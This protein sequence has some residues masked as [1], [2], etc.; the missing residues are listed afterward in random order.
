MANINLDKNKFSLN[1]VLNLCVVDTNDDGIPDALA[2]CNPDGSVIGQNTT[3]VQIKKIDKNKFNSAEIL[4]QVS[5]DIDGDDK[6]DAIAV[7][8]PNGKYLGK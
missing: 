3:Q 4:N 8:S 1:S 6:P 2:I 5:V 7:I